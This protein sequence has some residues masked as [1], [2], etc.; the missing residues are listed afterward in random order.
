MKRLMNS[1]MLRLT[2]LFVLITTFTIVNG[3]GS[4][5]FDDPGVDKTKKIQDLTQEEKTT[6][7]ELTKKIFYTETFKKDM[8][9]FMGI[10]S[11]EMMSAM[12]KD[13]AKLKTTCLDAE[14]KCTTD[15]EEFNVDKEKCDATVEEWAACMKTQKTQW[16]TILKATAKYSCDNLPAAG[17]KLKDADGNIIELKETPECK[18]FNSKC[19]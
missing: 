15:K 19:K 5:S 1:M 10:F 2:I 4:A 13:A 7:E 9:A 12:I 18:A 3:C 17:D 6:L 11:A 16:D 14:K 8:C